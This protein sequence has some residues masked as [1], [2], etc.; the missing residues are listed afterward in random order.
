MP[1]KKVGNQDETSKPK[2]KRKPGRPRKAATPKR[3][4]GR[5]P[6]YGENEVP[7]CCRFCGS[8]RTKRY[9]QKDY[10]TAPNIRRVR[11]RECQD[12]KD[13][14]RAVYRYTSTEYLDSAE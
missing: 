5:P 9:G 8:T 3:K 12:C 13:A 1:E 14:G 10:G 4:P 6:E 2:A 11:Y 7:K